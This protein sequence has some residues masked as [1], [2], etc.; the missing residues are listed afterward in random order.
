ME[1]YNESVR[2]LFLPKMNQK[3]L[4]IRSHDILGPY[5]EDLS[6]LAVTSSQEIEQLMEDG[7]KSRTVASTAM[8]AES[9]R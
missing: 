1:I 2:D 7:N 8:N 6:K 4:R 3:K 9:S 5:V